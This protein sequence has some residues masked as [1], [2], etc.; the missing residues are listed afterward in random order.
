MFKIFKTN[1]KLFNLQRSLWD[2][3]GS[4]WPAS[5]WDDWF[6]QPSQRRN[7]S[8]IRPEVSRTRTFGRVGVSNGQFYDQ[9]L[10]YIKLNDQIIDWKEFDFSKLKKNAYDKEFLANVHSL[11]SVSL[12]A[13]KERSVGAEVRLI[14]RSAASFRSYAKTIGIM[15]DFKSGVPRTAYYG[16]VSVLYNN[17]RVYLTPENPFKGYDE[18]WS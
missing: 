10:K 4:R 11:P 7:R 3:I 8:C 16:I 1:N 6:R 14:Y 13:I 15:D 18:T 17:I 2:E 12:S 9:Y 5:F